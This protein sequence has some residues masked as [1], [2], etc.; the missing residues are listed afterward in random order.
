MSQALEVDNKSGTQFWRKETKNEM[1]NN[2]IDFEIMDEGVDYKI[3]HQWIYFHMVFYVKTYSKRKDHYVGG[4]HQKDPPGSI[5][6]A[7]IVSW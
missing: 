6:Y 1:S 7:V 2:I 5:T 4:V 3:I